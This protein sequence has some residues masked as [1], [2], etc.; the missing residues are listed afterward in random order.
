MASKKSDLTDLEIQEYYEAYQSTQ[1]TLIESVTKLRIRN[2]GD[3][4]EGERAENEA[5]ILDLERKIAINE[6]NRIAFEANQHV[7]T[8]PTQGQLDALRDLVARVE[9]LTAN[10]RIV[11]EV[12]QL[13]T[14]SLNT[15]RQIHADQA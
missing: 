8:P 1:E 14:D 13:T 12:V 7:I 4:S 10:A 15:F 3:I 6:A 11:E 5:E 9:E 2:D